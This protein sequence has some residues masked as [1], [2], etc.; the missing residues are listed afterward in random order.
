M[1]HPRTSNYSELEVLKHLEL[2]GYSVL[3]RGWPDFIAVK[4]DEVRFIEVKPSQPYPHLKP[5][6]KRVASILSRFGITV[7][8]MTP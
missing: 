8:V 2:E 7:E 6:Q 5:D 1:R 4:G 3:K